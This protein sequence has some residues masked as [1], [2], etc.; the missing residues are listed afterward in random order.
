MEVSRWS[1]LKELFEEALDRPNEHRARFMEEACAGDSGLLTELRRLLANHAQAG[2]F[3][4]PSSEAGSMLQPGQRLAGRFTVVRMLGR[5]GMGEVYE[6]D[7]GQLNIRVALKTVLPTRLGARDGNARLIEEIRQARKITH[8]NVCR[9]FDVGI[10]ESGAEPVLFLTMELLE[11]ETLS[12]RLARLGP[13]P[14]AEAEAL[15]G[16]LAAALDAAHK[17]GVIHRDFKCANVMIARDGKA[18]VMD[19]GLSRGSS[20]QEGD[21]SLTGTGDLVG[22]PSY[23]APELLEGFPATPASD[24][25]AFGVVLCEVITGQ[26]PAA[27]SKMP[28]AWKAATHRCLDLDPQK[29]FPSAGDAAAA[30]RPL[31]WFRRHRRTRAVLIAAVCVLMAL[32]AA[33]LRGPWWDPKVPEGATL[34]LADVVNSTGDPSL[35]AL[36]AALHSQLSQSAHFELWD[37]RRRGSVLKQMEADGNAPLSGDL[38]RQAALREGV[39][40]LVAAGVSPVGDRLVLSMTLEKMEERSIFPRRVWSHHIVV[41]SKAAMN[42]ALHES[43]RWLRKTVGED[44]S[45]IAIHD[46]MPQ[47]TTTASWEA[48]QLYAQA[49]RQKLNDAPEAAVTL[50]QDAVR[51]DPHFA[52][53]HMRMGDVLITLRRQREG[54]REWGIAGEESNRRH[55]TRREE[56]HI[57]GLYAIELQNYPAAEAA[58]SQMENEYPKDYLASFYLGDALRWQG[59][60]EQSVPKFDAAVKKNPDSIAAVSNLAGVL[61]LCGRYRDLEDLLERREKAGQAELAAHHR[62][63]LAFVR[64]NFGAAE[65]AFR[66]ESASR[67]VDR[68][69]RGQVALAALLCERGHFQQARELLIGASVVDRRSGRPAMVAD[70]L[71]MLA[72]L[73]LRDGDGNSLRTRCLEA[74]ELDGGPLQVVRAA[75]LLARAGFVADASRLSRELNGFPDSPLLTAA[76]NRIEGEIELSLHRVKNAL[77]AFQRAA[78][79]E[80]ALRPKYYLARAYLAAGDNDRALPLLRRLADD[81][82]LF[83]QTSTSEDPGML[84]DSMLDL[85]A[86]ATHV[87]DTAIHNRAISLYALRRPDMNAGNAQGGPTH[88]KEKEKQ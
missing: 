34:M 5:G 26:K 16:D 58:F 82:A 31:P 12:S 47:D 32:S 67:S 35:N 45:E 53:A 20:R 38:A 70:K 69:S 84:T 3:L 29:R 46:R 42:D 48:L 61:L 30:L 63:M 59:K 83:W 22:T 80:P 57:R 13:L 60:L 36:G 68:A 44:P 71:L 52:L 27:A 6:V 87:G 14:A 17:S 21:A 65:D 73:D 54:L 51:L 2:L 10:D 23:M 8:P 55:L 33:I 79:A 49:E 74:A 19:F 28:P 88:L 11:G 39:P 76:R 81:S 24:V 75:S 56:L 43:S 15:A 25:Y 86:A 1:R 85:A 50:L 72:S 40:F 4:D 7:D 62:G 78:A 18:K 77:A 37:D 9:L 64:K 41:D 66:R